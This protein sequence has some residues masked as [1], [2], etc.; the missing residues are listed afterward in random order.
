MFRKFKDGT[1]PQKIMIY[2]GDFHIRRYMD[3]ITG[4]K[5]MDG[6]EHKILFS[7]EIQQRDYLTSKCIEVKDIDPEKILQLLAKPKKYN[8]KPFI[9]RYIVKNKRYIQIVKF[10]K[11]QNL[12]HTEASSVIPL[13]TEVYTEL[14][15]IDNKHSKRGAAQL[16]LAN[17]YITV[18]QPLSIVKGLKLYEKHEQLNKKIPEM[19]PIWKQVCPGINIEMEI[20]K[21]HAWELANP[22]KQKV[23]KIRFLGAWMNR[24]QDRPQGYQPKTDGG[25]YDKYS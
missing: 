13:S 12:H 14:Y 7:Q 19:I 22:K 23:D 20:K 16:E 9:Y 10:H 18:R 17:G 21:A 2:A 6:I 15:N 8:N 1:Y 5:Y 24:C 11:H 4:K 3:F 25:K